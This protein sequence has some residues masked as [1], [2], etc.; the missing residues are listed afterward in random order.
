MSNVITFG[1]TPLSNFSLYNNGGGTYNAPAKDYSMI[2]IQGRSG[3]LLYDNKR[4]ENYDLTYASCWIADNFET[5]IANLRAYLLSRNGYQRLEDTYH[6][7]EFRMAVCKNA[8]EIDVD[9]YNK[10]GSFDLVFNCKPQRFLKSGETK[11]TLTSNGVINNPT[12]FNSQPLLRV[13]GTGNVG[14]GSYTITILEADTYTDIDCELMDAYK[15]T[16]SKNDKIRLSNYTFPVLTP[17]QNGISLG[18]GITRVEITPRWW[19]I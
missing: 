3:D 13:Y 5:N 12:L 8:M 9:M 1:G 16:A 2:A 15:G 6:P 19:T 11:T 4:F 14:I 7:T 17:G 18:S 10:F